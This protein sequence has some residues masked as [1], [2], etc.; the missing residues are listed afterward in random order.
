M[1]K[2]GVEKMDRLIS[3]RRRAK[4]GGRSVRTVNIRVLYVSLR[5]R[6]R[7]LGNAGRPGIARML[8]V[9]QT[10]AYTEIR[11]HRRRQDYD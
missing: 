4:G 6:G 7:H 2:E 5:E 1:V 3:R 8:I 11:L 9:S 10:L